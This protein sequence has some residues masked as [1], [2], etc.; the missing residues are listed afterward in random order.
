[1]DGVKGLL[2][3]Y[4]KQVETALMLMDYARSQQQWASA[5][6]QGASGEASRLYGAISEKAKEYGKQ[7]DTFILDSSAQL[8]AGLSYMAQR[9]AHYSAQHLPAHLARSIESAAHLAEQLSNSLSQAESL[10]QVRSDILETVKSN[11][12]QVQ[13]AVA[14]TLNS[15]GDR[16]PTDWVPSR[17]S[18]SFSDTNEYTNTATQTEEDIES[19][20]AAARVFNCK[21]GNQSGGVPNMLD[22]PG[23]PAS[24]RKT[25][26]Q[27]NKDRHPGSPVMENGAAV[28][29]SPRSKCSVSSPRRNKQ[30]VR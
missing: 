23:L 15:I 1:V 11:F 10:G 20:T 27:K 25:Q 22:E 16:V 28:G 12:G 18:R 13:S 30:V 6:M 7:P 17:L 3:S 5:T 8:A 29:G 26:Q 19:T 2:T 4:T 21:N 24:P 9:M 14:A